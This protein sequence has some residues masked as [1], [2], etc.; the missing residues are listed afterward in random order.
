MKTNYF[1]LKILLLCVLFSSIYSYSQSFAGFRYDNYSGIQGVMYNP[2]LVVGSPYK[3]DINLASASLFAN[4]DY[5]SVDI[6]AILEGNDDQLIDFSSENNDAKKSNN[7]NVDVEALGPS[8]MFNLNNK[9]AIAVFSKARSFVSITGIDGTLYDKYTNGFDSDSD[10]DI[11]IQEA[12]MSTNIWSEFGVS[13]GRIIKEDASGTLKAGIS[14][15]YLLGFGTAFASFNNLEAEYFASSN[16]LNTSGGFEYGTSLDF[17][18]GSFDIAEGAKGF[19]LDFGVVYLIKPP[20]S[21]ASSSGYTTY[22]YSIGVSVTDIGSV[23]YS[24]A[25]NTVYNVNRTNIGADD[26]DIEDADLESVLQSV[27]SGQSNNE[28]LVAKLPTAAHINID[29]NINNSFFLNL[30]T[31]FSLSKTMNNASKTISNYSVTPRFQKKWI[32]VYSPINYDR[33]GNFG[34]GFG[35]RAGPLLVGSNTIVSS[36]LGATKKADVHVGL[37]I[38]IYRKTSAQMLKKEKKDEMK[39]M[40][41]EEKKAKKKNNKQNEKE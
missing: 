11:S 37:K 31:D 34:W 30:N 3:A 20:D 38:P 13:Y 28:P 27:Y 25:S 4:N 8:F 36:F 39:R 18:S 14:L 26:F 33:F 19:G 22:K 7:F 35:F 32:S 15:K 17:E 5:K 16:T 29:W 1:K 9:S 41:K 40:K 12:A 23:K 21:K 10:Y 2:A 6:K 24:E